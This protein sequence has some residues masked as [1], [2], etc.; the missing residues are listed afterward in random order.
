MKEKNI[1][2]KFFLLLLFIYLFVPLFAIILFSFAGKWDLSILPES[3]TFKYYQLILSDVDFRDAMVKTIGISIITSVL[4]MLVLVPCVYLTSVYYKRLSKL[5][6][7][8][9]VLPF[10][11]PGV[12]L[13]IGLIELYSNS[14]VDITGTVWILLGAYFVLCFPFMYQ[15]IGN[16]FRSI[17]SLRLTE[18]AKVLGCTELQAFVK[19]ILPNIAKGII[20]SILLSVSILFGEFVLVNLLVGNNYKTLQIYLYNALNTDGHTASAI[21]SMY[22][23]VI[24]I[25]S[26][27]AITIAG[28]PKRRLE[29]KE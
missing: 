18:A 28:K 22:L 26:Y 11:M 4:S 6:D 10:I 27:I 20:S 14:P 7:F 12:I 29:D 19:V 16:S 1:G 25:I 2:I 5:F 17:D 15:S 8:L 21:V 24:F 13:A 3:Y 23:I 9:A